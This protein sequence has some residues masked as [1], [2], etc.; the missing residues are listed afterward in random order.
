M[1]R[2]V[3]KFARTAPYAP[4]VPRCSETGNISSRYADTSGGTAIGVISAVV[5]AD[6]LGHEVV[7]P[8]EL[9]RFVEFKSGRQLSLTAAQVVPDRQENLPRQ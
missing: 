1:D 3:G 4:V 9:A 2:T 8:S 6:P 5:S 7:L